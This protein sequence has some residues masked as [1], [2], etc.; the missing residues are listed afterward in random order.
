MS[1]TSSTLRQLSSER[2]VP[3]PRLKRELSNEGLKLV[4]EALLLPPAEAPRSSSGA[5][6]GGWAC[7]G[8]A[9]GDF[10]GGHVLAPAVETTI[11]PS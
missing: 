10:C 11:S 8:D 1:T 3:V 7:E 4:R 5:A 6:G 9:R 2:G